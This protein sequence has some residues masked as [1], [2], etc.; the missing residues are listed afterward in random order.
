[1]D[2]RWFDGYRTGYEE[3]Y[4]VAMESKK[5]LSVATT[6][7]DPGELESAHEESYKK[8]LKLALKEKNE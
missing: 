2:D 4:R 1:M 7:Y 6:I 3:G 8:S 5:P